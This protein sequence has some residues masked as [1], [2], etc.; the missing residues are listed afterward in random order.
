MKIQVKPFSVNQAW[1][2]KRFRS[3]AY[4]QFQQDMMLMLPPLKIAFK[5]HLKVDLVFG[6]SSKAA[7]I[8][9]PIKPLLDILQKKYGFNDNQIYEMNV[10]K[11]ITKKSEE[12]IQLQIH[13]I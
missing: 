9:N 5:K 12:F 6:F 3:D 10:V 11:E 1:Q 8:D 2:G 7:D 4:K 13:E